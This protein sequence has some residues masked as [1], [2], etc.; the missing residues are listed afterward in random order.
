LTIV[1]DYNVN[2]ILEPI[3]IAFLEDIF[4]ARRGPGNDLQHGSSILKGK[5]IQYTYVTFLGSV[6]YK[7][8]EGH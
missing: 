6:V 2:A 5:Y 3:G 4:N 8:A 7:C 1:G